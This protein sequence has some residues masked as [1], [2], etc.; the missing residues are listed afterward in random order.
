MSH[1]KIFSSND[2]LN[3]IFLDDIKP[4]LYIDNI[5]AK[6]LKKKKV[7]LIYNIEKLKREIKKDCKTI[8][9]S[10]LNRIPSALKNI[11]KGMEKFYFDKD[12]FLIRKF[13]KIRHKM[14]LETQK[15]NQNLKGKINAGSLFFYNLSQ[16]NT[17]SENR[18]RESNKIKLRNSQ[19][20]SFTNEKD[21]IENEFLKIKYSMN[22]KRILSIFNKNSIRSNSEIPTEFTNTPRNIKKLILNMENNKK[23]LKNNKLDINYYSNLSNCKTSRN[24]SLSYGKTFSDFLTT[25]SKKN[26]TKKINNDI[27]K[28]S[29]YNNESE[30]DSDNNNKTNFFKLTSC[31]SLLTY[32]KPNE[33]RKKILLIDKNF[34]KELNNKINILKNS[35]NLSNK[36]ISNII[37]INKEKNQFTIYNKKINN[38]ILSNED[39]EE[40]MEIKLHKKENNNQKEIDDFIK[41]ANTEDYAVMN[42]DT[43]NLLK[44]TDKVTK[45]PDDVAL[46]LVDNY[47]KEYNKTRN[48]SEQRNIIKNL[49]KEKIRKGEKL[50]L[51]EKVEYNY[52]KMIKLNNSLSFEKEMLKKKLENLENLKNSI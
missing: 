17:S 16:K 45:M 23:N 42:H 28:K 19:I 38:K 51:R 27:K 41:A 5:N 40:I 37:K 33:N 52:M 18:F 24:T 2:I 10:N 14:L 13:P 31:S 29:D 30:K 26:K 44:L 6:K 50:E 1:K 32:K 3:D 36:Q 12:S 15:K 22:K 46:F 43:R 35:I 20:F 34:K 47:T 48:K 9:G 8:S 7:N 25:S 39:V 21:S 4:T 11:R 49:L